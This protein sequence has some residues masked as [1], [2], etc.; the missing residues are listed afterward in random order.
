LSEQSDFSSFREDPA[1]NPPRQVSG[2]TAACV[3]ISNVIG[4]GIFTTTGF[5]ARDLGDAKWILL[6]WIAGGLLALIGAMCYSE[7]GALL[8]HVGGEYV[9]IQKAYGSFLG[10]LSGWASF[11]IG[12][13]AGVAAGSIS[14]ASYL[15]QLVPFDH[16]PT[17]LIKFVA[18]GL[19]WVL[20][21]VH[22]AGVGPGGI[23]QQILTLIKI[24]SIVGLIVAAFS[25]GN[26]TGEYFT[27]ETHTPSPSWGTIVISMIFVSYAYSGWNA[28]GYIA[29]EM[30]NPCRNIPRAMIGGTLVVCGLYFLLNLVYVYALP[31]HV[32]GTPPVLPVAEK[33]SVALFGPVAAG[34]VTVILCIS[35]AG[36]VSAMVW[37]GP[38]VYYAMAKDGVFPGIFAQLRSN[39]G[40]PTK[41]ILLQSLWASFLIVTGT[42][43]QLVIYS[44]I[45]IAIFSSLAVGAVMILRWS[46]P[47]LPRPYSV[48]VYPLLP[49]LYVAASACMVV[50]TFVERTAES[51]WAVATVLVGVP[52]YV[53]WRAKANKRRQVGFMNS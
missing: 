27:L 24:G 14:F 47:N 11:T 46:R 10:F 39:G 36:A 37:I 50:Y 9:Y 12:F 44:G 23:L 1:I 6:L 43:E 18:L 3:L 35:M 15:L 21:A 48:P 52:L 42:F 28:A 5:L 45:I 29:G 17:L 34:V 8:P 26:G 4:A 53:F 22:R 33:A 7:L 20:T 40:A 38:R 13:G 51:L 30:I 31:V 2:F 19:V 41:A 25:L 16:V 32:L 49:G